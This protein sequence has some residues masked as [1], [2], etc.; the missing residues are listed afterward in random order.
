MSD[1]G[2]SESS[3]LGELWCPDGDEEF[4]LHVLFA[5][6]RLLPFSPNWI[7]EIYCSQMLYINGNQKENLIN[8]GRLSFRQ[9][10]FCVND[11]S[12]DGSEGGQRRNLKR[13]ILFNFYQ[14]YL[15]HSLINSNLEILLR[16][17]P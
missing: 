13:W 14:I 5:R 11:F 9:V 6:R 17:I 4:I 7:I 2:R 3:C 10:S 8:S 15:I 1:L 16:L 12:T